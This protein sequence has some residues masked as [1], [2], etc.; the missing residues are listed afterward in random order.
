VSRVRVGLVSVRFQLFDNEMPSDFPERMKARASRFAEI[1]S[2]MFD[3]Y[4]PGLIENPEDAARV[5]ADLANRDFDVIVFAP[6]MAAPPSYAVTATAG[7]PRVPIVIWNAVETAEMPRDLTQAQ[8]TESSTTVASVMF[9]NTLVRQGR[10]TNVLTAS[11]DDVAGV[12]ILRRTIVG[13]ATAGR[14]RGSQAVRFGDPIAG[15]LD[16]EASEKQ[17]NSLGVSEAKV[18]VGE[19]DRALDS[20]TALE[21]QEVQESLASRGW[22]GDPGAHAGRSAALYLA[23]RALV[24][25]RGAVC[26]TVNCHG[27]MFRWNQNVGITACLGVSL[28]TESGIPVTCTGDMPTALCLFIAKSMSSAALY[29]ECYAPELNSGLMLLAAGGEGDPSWSDTSGGVRIQSNTHYPGVAGA[30]T[31]INFRLQRGPATLMSL[32]PRLDGWRLVWAT[33]EVVESR[34]DA[35]GGP[36]GMFRFDSGDATHMASQW[37]ASGATH[38]NALAP[39]R[40]DVEIPAFAAASEIEAIRI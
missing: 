9:A 35:M 12:D 38:H 33:G 24:S 36:N 32:S 16:V 5:G 7:L 8:A 6:A 34:F 26:A 40:L 20:V 11:P 15:Y 21:I 4:Y 2:H 29:N 27:P 37:I 39:G 23:L 1:L 14:L 30:G 13:A 31:S 10:K 17:L 19:L 22:R 3:V 25:D 18:S 28:L